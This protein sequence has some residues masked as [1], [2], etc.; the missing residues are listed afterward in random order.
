MYQFAA[1]KA[2]QTF[3]WEMISICPSV[4]CVHRSIPEQERP[5][6]AAAWCCPPHACH[7]RFVPPRWEVA[8]LHLFA[9]PCYWEANQRKPSCHLL[10][11]KSDARDRVSLWPAGQWWPRGV[12]WSFGSK[13]RLSE[14][15]ETT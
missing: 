15:G 13:W 6:W 9:Q 11:L 12:P 4:Q 5:L 10:I 3:P 1:P 7:R 8:G 14:G 2:P